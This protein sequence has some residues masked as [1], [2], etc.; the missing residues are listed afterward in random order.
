MATMNF[1]VSA[2]AYK[3]IGSI[4]TDENISQTCSLYVFD[5]GQFDAFSIPAMTRSLLQINQHTDCSPKG[6]CIFALTAVDK[7][8]ATTTLGS[9]VAGGG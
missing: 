7:I 3:G 9:V 6:S 8:S 5:I 4:I 2:M 1:I